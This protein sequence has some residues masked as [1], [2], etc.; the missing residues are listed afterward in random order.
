MLRR[1]RAPGT[2][3]KQGI[4]KALTAEMKTGPGQLFAELRD[5]T[6]L[7]YI[8]ADKA[9]VRFENLSK[10]DREVLRAFWNRPEPIAIETRWLPT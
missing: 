1:P 5:Q 6:I 3:G 9:R 10:A 7:P 4:A 2:T 8:D